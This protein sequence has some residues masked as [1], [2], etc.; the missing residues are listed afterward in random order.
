MDLWAAYDEMGSDYERHAADSAYNAHYDRPAVLAA[1]GPV[2][3]QRVLD[4]ACGPGLYAESLLAAGAEV[5]G[6]DASQAMVDLARQRLGQRAQIDLARLGKALPYPAEAFDSS[7]C[8]L[9]IH[10]VADRPAAFAELYRVLRA[11]GALVVSTQHPTIDWLRKGGSYFDTM[12]ETD[13]WQLSTGDQEVRFWREPLSRL[14]AAATSAGFVIDQLIEP[15][16][17]QSMRELFPND[18]DTLNRE[19]GFLILSLRKMR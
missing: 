9:A 18:Y 11:G 16:P 17:A 2:T 19:P 6:F 4:A 8:A 7:I 13:T 10:Y 15:R 5:V 14:C 1:L 3:G 12:L